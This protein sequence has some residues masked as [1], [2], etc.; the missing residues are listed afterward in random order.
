MFFSST[1]PKAPVSQGWPRVSQR[2]LDPARTTEWRPYHSHDE[3][4]KLKQGEVY[5]I[6]VENLAVEPRAAQGLP[7]RLTCRARIST[8]RASRAR[9]APMVHA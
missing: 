3:V 4:Q 8:G 7:D 2:K 5:E 6:D 1:A 9:P